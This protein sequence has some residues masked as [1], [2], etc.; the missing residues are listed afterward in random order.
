MSL[1]TWICTWNTCDCLISLHA[2]VW[3]ESIR[4]STVA[5]CSISRGLR[6]SWPVDNPIFHWTVLSSTSSSLWL[7]GVRYWLSGLNSCLCCTQESLLAYHTV[8]STSSHCGVAS[9]KNHKVHQD[10]KVFKTNM[11][12][13]PRNIVQ[14]LDQMEDRIRMCWWFSP[15]VVRTV[16]SQWKLKERSNI[17]VTFNLQELHTKYKQLIG[18]RPTISGLSVCIDHIRLL[19]EWITVQVRL[20]D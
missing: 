10:S 13:S 14:H 19:V 6:I 12:S 2:R 11:K 8:G 18:R 20:L 17:D 3:R 16:R 4:S 5:T 7:P 15:N 9:C 1:H